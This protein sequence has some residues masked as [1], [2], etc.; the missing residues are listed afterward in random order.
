MEEPWT[1]KA[2][3]AILAPMAEPFVPLSQRVPYTTAQIR[4][5][6]GYSDGRGNVLCDCQAC[7]E[8]NLKDAY[9]FHNPGCPALDC[10]TC[11]CSGLSHHQGSWA[12][13]YGDAPG[14]CECTGFI[15]GMAKAA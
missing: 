2:W 7:I 1:G 3:C 6:F 12:G 10:D 9:G 8:C 15:P 5:L 14:G 4:L 11:G 13:C